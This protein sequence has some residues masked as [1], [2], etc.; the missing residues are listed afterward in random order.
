MEGVVTASE[1][2]ETVD[3]FF[4]LVWEGGIVCVRSKTHSISIR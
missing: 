4:F 2:E 3:V 1:E